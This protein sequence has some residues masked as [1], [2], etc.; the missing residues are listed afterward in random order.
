V[1]LRGDQQSPD[2]FAIAFVY[3]KDEYLQLVT[4]KGRGILM[5]DGVVGHGY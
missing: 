4:S 1:N 2:Q 5:V 3:G